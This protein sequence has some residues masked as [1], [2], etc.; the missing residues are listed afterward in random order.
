MRPGGA[1]GFHPRAGSPK[2]RLATRFGGELIDSREVRLLDV[3]VLLKDLLL[4]HA[5]AEPAED[6]P[7]RN[8]E[9][10]YRGRRISEKTVPKLLVGAVG[11][12]HIALLQ[13]PKLQDNGLRPPPSE[14]NDDA[15]NARRCHVEC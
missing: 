1:R 3:G 10:S 9:T 13:P 4:G 7:D 2:T 6:I 8:A 14:A 15:E 11:S 12:T 5:G